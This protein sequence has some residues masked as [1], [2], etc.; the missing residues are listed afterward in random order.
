LA[1]ATAAATVI[2]CGGGGSGGGGGGGVLL[3]MLTVCLQCGL[4]TAAGG[5]LEHLYFP[6]HA[7]TCWLVLNRG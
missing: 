7:H 1:A 4:L 6:G 2:C 5:Y 3:M